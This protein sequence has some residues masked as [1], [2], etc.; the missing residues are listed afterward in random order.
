MSISHTRAAIANCIFT[1]NHGYYAGA[2]NIYVSSPTITN[3]LFS[4]NTSLYGGAIKN[5]NSS[6][7]IL[8]CIISGNT[9]TQNGGGID[10]SS[11][12]IIKN[13]ILFGNSA[14]NYGGGI[15][16][17]SALLV[18]MN[19][20]FSGNNA[21]SA[22]GAIYNPGSPSPS[23]TNCILWQDTAPLGPE[24]R[25]SSI[26]LSH[27]DVDQ[28]GY[29]GSD[30]NI[31]Q[32]PL[33]VDPVNDDYRL[34]AYSPCTD[35]ADGDAAPA[36]DIVGTE[37]YDDPGVANTGIGDP[38]YVDI[39]AYERGLR[40]PIFV[41]ADAT[42][43]NNGSSW[44]D[45]YNFIRDALTDD[46]YTI[47]LPV[48]VR[49]AEGIYKPDED[50]AHPNGSGFKTSFFLKWGV[51]LKGGYAGFD[52]PDPNTRNIEQYKTILSGDLIGDDVGY[53]DDPSRNDNAWWVVKTTDT[54]AT[55]VLD[56]F[57]VTSG[58]A[59]IYNGGG[60]YNVRSSPTVLNCTFLR[61]SADQGG[62]MYSYQGGPKLF[63]CVFSGNLANKY[64]GGIGGSLSGSLSSPGLTNCTFSGNVAVMDSGGIYVQLGNPVVTNCIFWGNSDDDGIDESAQI[65]VTNGTPLI[66][67]CCIEGW[68]GTLGGT[69]NI[70]ADPLFIDLD[71]PDNIVGT[72]DDDL[73]LSVGS[74]CI[75]AGDNDAVPL[76]TADVDGDGDTTELIPWDL[77]GKPR[78]IDD[79][80]TVDTGN[81]TAPI[82]D[83][84]AYEFGAWIND[85]PVYR[86]W[87]P[88]NSRHFY[89]IKEAEKNKLINIY[90]HVWTYE[91]IVYY[92]FETD[93]EPS[94]VPVYRFWSP[95]LVAH[96]YT[97]SES[98]RDKLIN[99]YP[100]VWTYEGIAFYAY[101]EGQQPIDT[102]PVYR[103]W[104]DTLETHFYTMNETEKN[105]LIDNY[106]HV[107]TYEG[108]AWYAYE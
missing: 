33:F 82:V 83:M 65:Y 94:L 26:H 14:G 40:A 102:L 47:G 41:D 75:D 24:I 7:N 74:P 23:V 48:E 27:C 53:L 21:D 50:S 93:S 44:D 90:A 73:R 87:S 81:G 79:P 34:Q 13:C 52:H 31:R 28:D 32:D 88:I 97:I 95:V 1:D 10:N 42:G 51:T 49:V 36:A 71:G 22:G 16:N 54:A 70:G 38:D 64:G 17:Y 6:T 4:G 2:I 15:Y 57:T 3:C 99:I 103:F 100:H 20:T 72:E 8:N 69:G 29:A 19:C 101:P 11:E 30:G 89:T 37:R 60:M 35:A 66:N 56:G 78:F 45:A 61:N 80:D 9:A 76:D 12:L 59:E 107:W 106:P 43:A 92:A 104:S 85:T 84:G 86:F 63:N 67:G 46:S 91:G 39:G 105:K 108:T 18:V 96:F 5:G 77:D 68:T 98:E 25:G 58:S 55:V 62:G